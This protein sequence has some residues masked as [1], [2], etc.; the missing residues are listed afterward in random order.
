M[1]ARA[2]NRDDIVAALQEALADEERVL[3]NP[4]ELSHAYGRFHQLLIQLSGSQTFEVSSQ[5][6]AGSFRPRPTDT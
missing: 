6:R 3:D 2:D 1:L 5:C 4:A